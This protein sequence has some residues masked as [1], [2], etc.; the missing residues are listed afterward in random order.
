ML[1]SIFVYI[2]FHNQHSKINKTTNARKFPL[3][4]GSV[5]PLLHLEVR[6]ASCSTSSACRA[7]KQ[8]LPRVWALP[9]DPWSG[10]NQAWKSKQPTVVLY[11]C[12]HKTL[13]TV[14]SQRSLH[15]TNS[16]V[17]HHHHSRG[18]NHKRDARRPQKELMTHKRR[19]RKTTEVQ[20]LHPLWQPTATLTLTLHNEAN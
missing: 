20:G 16:Q 7:E 19:Q 18:R 1:K 14:K 17:H 4:R 10:N 15:W 11:R 13:F 8:Q 9:K 3:G 5:A 12:K 6:Q 2:L